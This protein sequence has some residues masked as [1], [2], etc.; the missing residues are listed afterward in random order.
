M[1]ARPSVRPRHAM[2]KHTPESL[3]A[4]RLSIKEHLSSEGYRPSVNS[5][6]EIMFHFDGRRCY[7]Q[8]DASDHDYARIIIVNFRPIAGADDFARVAAA[9]QDV[10]ACTKVIKIFVLDGDTWCVA[11]LLLPDPSRLPVVFTRSLAAIRTALRAF[12]KLL[13]SAG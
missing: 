1:T 7:L 6:G 4:L 11:E 13:A 5:D 8:T 3:A 9:A 12:E 10:T 2:K